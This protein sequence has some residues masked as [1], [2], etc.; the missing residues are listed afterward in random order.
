[1]LE[2]DLEM[3]GGFL[4]GLLCAHTTCLLSALRLVCVSAGPAHPPP[5]ILSWCK[6]LKSSGT[7]GEG[8]QDG[9]H[10][11]HLDA[12]GSAQLGRFPDA[13]VPVRTGPSLTH[14]EQLL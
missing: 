1:M 14:L 10:C 13:L 8:H 12:G 7:R 4:R 5:L 11:G 3:Q 6:G 9:A 2:L